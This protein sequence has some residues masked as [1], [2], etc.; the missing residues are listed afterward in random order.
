MAGRGLR[1]AEGK[2]RLI[3]IDHS[4][5]V[6]RHGLLEDPVQW[7]L[8][9]D[10]RA[11]NPTH[12]SRSASIF[13]K[14]LECRQCGALRKGGEPCSHRGFRPQRRPEAIIFADG[15]LA[16]VRNGKAKSIYSSGDRQRWYQQLMALRLVRNEH[17]ASN[18]KEPLKST[19]AA[20]KYKDKFGSWPPFDWNSLP[21]A[22]A[23][24]QEI[25]SWVR[26]RDIAFAKR[27]S[28]ERA[29]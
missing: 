22:A 3:L 15:D 16:E 11:E 1:P 23:V 9:A 26:S 14:L 29:A 5:A 24:S 28:K 18:G 25:Q 6:F 20:A 12:A 17:R 21:P 13:S 27:L 10:E 2:D 19:W 4:G 8:D 7:T